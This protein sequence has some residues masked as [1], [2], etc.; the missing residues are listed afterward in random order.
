M[1][2]PKT[3]RTLNYNHLF[4]FY[5]TVKAGGVTNAAT[6]LDL[7]QPSLSSQLKILEKRLKVQLFEK[8][9]RNRVPTT[10]GLNLY[11]YCAKMFEIGK[12][13]E[14]RFLQEATVLTPINKLKKLD[15]KM[16]ELVQDE[17]KRVLKT[18]YGL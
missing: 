4:Y 2:K 9:G 3:N 10:N 11:N 7:S 8:D 5:A 17:V 16:A 1:E 14:E 12:H 13:I 18:R 15:P 6:A